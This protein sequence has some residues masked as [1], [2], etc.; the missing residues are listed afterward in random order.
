VR[1]AVRIESSDYRAMMT[2]R[3][4]CTR[5]NAYETTSVTE[6]FR[7]AGAY[8]LIMPLVKGRPLDERLAEAHGPLPLVCRQPR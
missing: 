2:R 8:Y 7:E 1:A 4:R 3:R 6:F 5:A